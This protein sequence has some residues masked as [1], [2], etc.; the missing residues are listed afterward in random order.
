M[1]KTS[2]NSLFHLLKCSS[3]GMNLCMYKMAVKT[4][5]IRLSKPVGALFKIP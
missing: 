5:I 4:L 2:I 3:L 1:L